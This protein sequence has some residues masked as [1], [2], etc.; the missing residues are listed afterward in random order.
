MATWSG[1]P[2][3]K[4]AAGVAERIAGLFPPHPAY[5]EAFLGWGG[6][7]RRKRRAAV[8]VGIDVDRLVCAKWEAA[9][10]AGND[11]AAGVD[12]ICGDALQILPSLPAAQDPEAVVYIDAPYILA[13][14]TSGRLLYRHELT[15]VEAHD[16]VIDVARALGCRVA[17]SHYAHPLYLTRL[18]DWRR[19]EI[20]AMTRGG[21]R[22]E[23][24]WLNFPQP[25]TFHDPYLANV[26]H[27]ERDRVKRRGNRWLARLDRLP[28]AERQYI[29]DSLRARLVRSDV[30]RSRPPGADVISGG[31]RRRGIL[32][33]VSTSP[34]SP[35][36]LL[37]GGSQ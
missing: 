33:S 26:G 9:A 7:M 36:S 34:T 22:V 10:D 21:K 2:G 23:C 12:V 3:S 31:G 18:Q 25:T 14:R 16:V 5:V 11:V 8:N 17:V 28:P 30:G 4:S 24:V 29:E 6:V 27:R 13:S 35:T 19:V 32:P 37:A 20:P 15:T 1:Y